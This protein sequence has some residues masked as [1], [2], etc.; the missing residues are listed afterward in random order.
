MLHALCVAIDYVGTCKFPELFVGPGE[1][2]A[3]KTIPEPIRVLAA[4]ANDDMPLPKVAEKLGMTLEATEMNL[5]TIKSALSA[6]T[7][8]A[9]IRHAITTKLITYT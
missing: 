4:L 8:N 2:R 7:N 1:S 5:R 9:A 3:A 6:K